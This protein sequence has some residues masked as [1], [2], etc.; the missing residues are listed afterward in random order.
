MKPMMSDVP[1]TIARAAEAS[2]YILND[3]SPWVVISLVIAGLLHSVLTPEKFQRH[4]GNRKMSSL[5]KATLSGML[6]PI[7]SCGV[8]PLGLGMYYSGAYLGPTLAFMVATPIINPAAILLAYGLLGPKIATIYLV[9]GFLIPFIIGLT[10]NAMAGPEMHAPGADNPDTVPALD[11]PADVGLRRKLLAGLEW[12]FQDLGAMTGKYIVFGIILA[13]V[14]IAVVPPQYIQRYLGDPGMVSV[15]GIAVLGAVMYV[16]AV[17]HIPLIAALVAS[18]AAPGVAITFLMT[19][20]ATNLPELVSIYKLIGKRAVAIYAGMLTGLSIVVG[21]FTNWLL[22]PGFVPFFNL[23]EGRRIVGAA[24]WLIL[25]VPKPIQ[26][27]TS[28][29]VVLLCLYALRPTLRK[30]IPVEGTDH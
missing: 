22:T 24:N 13:G 7:C 14:I 26:Y 18:G 28:C 12:G 11:E 8:I 3:V 2:F 17:G 23:D 1:A 10:A 9:S 4:L 15:L 25:A 16:C 27:V 21:F 29:V 6:L 20:A 30:F 5:V 19:G